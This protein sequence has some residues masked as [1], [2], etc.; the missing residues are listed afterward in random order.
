[1]NWQDHIVVQ[2]EV[3]HGKACIRG[4]R[5]MASVVMDNLAEGDSHAEMLQSYPQLR[6]EDLQAVMH[7]AAALARDRV[8]PLVPGAA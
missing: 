8:V 4:T 6:E 7:Y 1:M 3:C 5:I 2:P